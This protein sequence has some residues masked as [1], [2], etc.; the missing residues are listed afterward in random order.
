MFERHLERNLF[1]LWSDLEGGTYR[2]GAYQSFE[3]KDSKRRRIDKASVRDRVVHEFLF[4]FLQNIFEPRFIAD[5]Y[6]SRTGKGTLKALK[7]ADAFLSRWRRG[8]IG[9]Y[10]VI[11]DVRSFFATVPHSVLLERIAE[12]VN[13]PRL[14]ML[15]KDVVESFSTVGTP[16]LGIPLGNVTSQIFANIVLHCFDWYVKRTLQLRRYIRYNDD[17]LVVIFG[18]RQA[19]RVGVMLKDAIQKMNLDLK[20]AVLPLETRT[21]F[22]WLG[23]SHSISSRCVRRASKKRIEKAIKKGDRKHRRRYVTTNTYRNM[24]ASY[25]AHEKAYD[26]F[27]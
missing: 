6:S 3:L 16:G 23:A 18:V 13:D 1:Q 27:F 7:K 19:E 8:R 12:Q 22:D 25:D 21:H 14:F 5:S 4:R 10:A 26:K 15:L 9:W 17:I 11:C 24:L 20:V 2:H